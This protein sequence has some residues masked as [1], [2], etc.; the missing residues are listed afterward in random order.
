MPKSAYHL[1]IL[2]LFVISPAVFAQNANGNYQIANQLMLQ[3][4]YDDA[5]PLLK[6]AYKEEPQV[7]QFFEKLIDCQ[8]QLKNYDEAISLINENIRKQDYD[9]RS[10]VKL[11]EVYHFKEDTT[12]AFEIWD[13]NLAENSSNL[14]VYSSTARTMADRKAYD[15]AIKVYEKARE[16]FNNPNMFMAEV[17][18]V[19]MQ[20]GEYEL[21]IRE[22][23]SLIQRNP[24]QSSYFQRLLF[25]YNDPFLYDISILELDDKLAEMD[26]ND[27]NYSGFYEL[28]IWLLL[29]NELYRRAYAAA[30][31]F[32]S[33]TSSYNF[34]LFNVGRQLTDANEFELALNA[35]DYYTEQTHGE[36][37][38][39][40]MEEKAGVY[41]RWAKYLDDNSLDFNKKRDSLF[42]SSIQ[43]LD[44]IQNETSNYSRIGDVYLKRAELALDFIFDL[45]AASQ[46]LELLKRVPGN[47]YLA[48]IDYLQGR[49]KLAEQ[50][51]TEARISLTRSNKKAGVGDLAEKT[52]YFLSLTDFYAGDYEFAQIQLKTLG[53]QN[54]SYYANDALKLRLW[55]QEGL[56]ED[57]TG[58][59]LDEF[60]SAQFDL[61]TN[62]RQEAEQKLMAIIRSESPSPFVDDAY[63][64]LA[65]VME[66]PDINYLT[67]LTAHLND[68]PY[69]N[70][71]EQLM[72]EKARL[73]ESLYS[74]AVEIH[75]TDSPDEDAI[76]I[77]D[78]QVQ[79]SL[80]FVVEAYEDLILN[81]PQGFYAPYARARLKELPKANS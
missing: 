53:R 19:Y 47:A 13:K 3:Q 80:S 69:S 39:R 36:I 25:R 70:R 46:S 49:I 52:R 77:E 2:L 34:S 27:P 73:A 16:V 15:R 50:N 9:S 38:W 40:A 12:R 57:T 11:G 68:S 61:A 22:W 55:I 29:E 63:L 76:I 72:W 20:A 59:S 4:R 44:A 48:Q 54:T 32:E 24:K 79:T 8:I 10:Y 60:A 1:F 56:A 41:S 30:R 37:K 35:F 5:L 7:F 17:P 45:N 67:D 78:G 26:I 75:S 21:A 62:K 14:Q 28:Q 31:E 33:K 43:L 18:N 58:S 71:K 81:F 74:A 23:L 51:F 42:T 65:S 66:K 6:K 64:M